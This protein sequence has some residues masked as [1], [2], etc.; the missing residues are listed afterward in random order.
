M[1]EEKRLESSCCFTGHRSAKLPWRGNE[2]DP[3]CAALKA[4]IAEAVEGLYDQGVRHFICGM[5]TGCDMYFA[6]AVA[7]LR[8]RRPGVTLEAAIPCEDQDRR[9]THELSE[10][11]DG[12]LA[13]CDSRTLISRSYTPECMMR[14]NRYMV[15]NAGTVLAVFNGSPGGTFNTL[16][17]AISLGRKIVEIDP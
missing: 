14:R 6:E 5:A 9:W 10:R 11:Y 2:A 17:Y 16:R 3:R 4:R 1:E 8:E 15:D 13:Q 12:L 7:A